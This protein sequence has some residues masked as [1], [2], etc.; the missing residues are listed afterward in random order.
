MS[1]N[2]QTYAD[3]RIAEDKKEANEMSYKQFPNGTFTDLNRTVFVNSLRDL[4]VAIPIFLH[5]WQSMESKFRIRPKLNMIRDPDMVKYQEE[6]GSH[7]FPAYVQAD[8]LFV[9][10]KYSD[11][12]AEAS[13]LHIK[14]HA[15]LCNAQNSWHGCTA[16]DCGGS[17]P[18][19]V[20]YLVGRQAGQSWYVYQMPWQRRHRGNAFN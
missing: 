16:N 10:T 15:F 2:F 8:F 17:S 5:G 12:F 14:Y 4:G 1:K 19:A 11:E 20:V 13:R 18:G 3:V 7:L 6:D 9:P